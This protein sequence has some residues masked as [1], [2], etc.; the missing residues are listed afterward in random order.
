MIAFTVDDDEPKTPSS[1]PSPCPAPQIALAIPNTGRVWGCLRRF[2][3]LHFEL[4]YYHAIEI[5]IELGLPRVEA[6]AQGE[7]KIA[8]GY[9]PTLTYSAH[10]LRDSG[11]RSAVSKFLEGEREQTYIAM[12]TLATQRNPFQADPAPHLASQGLQIQGDRLVVNEMLGES[13]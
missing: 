7:H 10:Y 5:A 13:T 3:C 1:T 8:R 2:D 12:A 6:G 9:M 11:F 4:C